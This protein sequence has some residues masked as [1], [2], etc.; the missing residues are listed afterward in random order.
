M[1]G[2]GIGA[3]GAK[4][5]SEMMKLNSTLTAL[6]LSREEERK[7]NEKEKKDE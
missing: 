7:E 4:A 1:T 2:N 3:E 6:N 5:M